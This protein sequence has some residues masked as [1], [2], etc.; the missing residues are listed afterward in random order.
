MSDGAKIGRS[1]D[2]WLFNREK[3]ALLLLLY[4]AYV[5]TPTFSV[6]YADRFLVLRHNSTFLALNFF[7]HRMRHSPHAMSCNRLALSAYRIDRI[8]SQSMQLPFCSPQLR[9]TLYI[10]H[11]LIDMSIRV[12]HLFVI[13]IPFHL[14]RRYP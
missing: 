8:Q 9:A 5:R 3:A 7:P 14:T 1:N 13:E 10:F 4:N 11:S 12:P 2:I 6:S